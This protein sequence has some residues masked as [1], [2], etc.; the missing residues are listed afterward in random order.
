VI[1]QQVVLT[2]LEQKK[3]LREYGLKQDLAYMHAKNTFLAPYRNKLEV[4]G[5]V[6]YEAMSLVLDTKNKVNSA[7]GRIEKQVCVKL[8]EVLAKIPL[9]VS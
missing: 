3:H 2:Q 1:F 9:T 8:E 5:N 7:V 6:L 4:S